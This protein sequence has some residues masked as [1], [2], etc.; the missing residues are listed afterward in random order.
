MKREKKGKTWRALGKGGG[1]GGGGGGVKECESPSE[2]LP[3]QTSVTSS[4]FS[5]FL[6]TKNL[7][8]RI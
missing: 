1:G 3:L 8:F 6:P 5:H 7:I 2:F 4:K